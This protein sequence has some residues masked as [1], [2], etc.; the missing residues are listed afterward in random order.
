MPTSYTDQFYYID[1]YSPP[2]NGTVMNFVTLNMTDQS[3]DSDL[4]AFDG[5]SVHGLDIQSSWPGDMVQIDLG[6][7]SFVTYAG[8]T[9]YLSDGSQVFTPT[10]GQILENWTLVDARGV[11]TQGPLDVN[12]LGPPCFAAGIMIETKCGKTPVEQI[13]VGN[14]VRTLDHGLQP[15][16]W[17]G[18]PG[19]PASR[20]PG[21][22]ALGQ[23]RTDPLCTQ[24]DRECA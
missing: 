4:D 9:F 20:R 17:R 2:P 1:H 12:D 10:D 3:N 8:T 16:Q 6:G 13:Q 24:C 7:G 23:S 19:V 18:S 22:P 11:T 15:V 5:D 14:L 21:V